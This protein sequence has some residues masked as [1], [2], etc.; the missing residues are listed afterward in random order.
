MSKLPSSPDRSTLPDRVGVRTQ[1]GKPTGFSAFTGAIALAALSQ[2][3]CIVEFDCKDNIPCKVGTGV[4]AQGGTYVCDGLTD[5]IDKKTSKC[6]AEPLPPTELPEISCDGLDN[7]CDGDTDEDGLCKVPLPDV[8]TLDADAPDVE[9]ATDTGAPDAGTP[10]A[11]AE[12]SGLRTDSDTG[13]IFPD[14]G[15]DDSGQPQPD[16]GEPDAE[17][18][19]DTGSVDV[20]GNVPDEGSPDAEAQDSG[21]HT[22]SDTGMIFPDAGSDAGQ[23]DGGEVCQPTEDLEISCD[24]IDNDCDGATDED[25]VF[26]D[27]SE[28]VGSCEAQGQIVCRDG[29]L[30]CDALPGEPQEEACDDE[31]NDCDGLIDLDEA[32]RPLQLE[33]LSPVCGVQGAE[34]CI[35]GE[36]QPC[37]AVDPDADRD[38]VLDCIDNCPDTSNPDQQDANQSGTGDACEDSMGRLSCVNNGRS[39]SFILRQTPNARTMDVFLEGCGNVTINPNDGVHGSVFAHNIPANPGAVP[40][41]ARVTVGITPGVLVSG[42]VANT[43]GTQETMIPGNP[44]SNCWGQ[45]FQPQ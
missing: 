33:C 1:I 6:S 28:G 23:A 27:C 13:M 40:E 16:E 3:G 5:E 4:C 18:S 7:D 26:G 17:I 29:E 42:C 32:N 8:G 2:A 19:V 14:T 36:F 30:E 22:D 31:D 39:P 21:L 37:T 45:S 15:G 24:N 20:G 10:D 11:E 43:D 12:D 44:N 9:T 38:L 34:T 35:G 25:L 41:A